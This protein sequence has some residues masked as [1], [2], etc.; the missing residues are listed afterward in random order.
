MILGRNV[1]LVLLVVLCVTACGTSP[2]EVSDTVEDA[3]SL[4]LADSGTDASLSSDTDQL[5]EP[6]I[7]PEPD[8]AEDVSTPDLSVTDIQADDINSDDLEPEDVTTT[9]LAQPDV[10][11]ED[12]PPVLKG[13]GESCEEYTECADGM[14]CISGQYTK[15]HCN[16]MC[17]TDADCLAVTPGSKPMCAAIGGYNVCVWYC[18]MFGGGASCPGDLECDGATCG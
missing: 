12:V 18:G 15:A 11:D 8:L 17:T 10:P 16:P 5:Q 14:S 3:A 13:A 7:N 4:D 6:D 9:D 1:V 2:T